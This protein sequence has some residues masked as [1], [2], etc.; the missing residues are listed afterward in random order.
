MWH[1]EDLLTAT[2]LLELC[3]GE[4]LFA[5]VAPPG[6][7]HR[8]DGKVF[9]GADACRER[10]AWR[11]SGFPQA[12]LILLTYP[13]NRLLLYS[14]NFVTLQETVFLFINHLR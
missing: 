6:R 2:T 5:V 14:Y 1:G 7:H 4:F 3:F 10:H 13:I 8:F 12:R 9:D 11:V